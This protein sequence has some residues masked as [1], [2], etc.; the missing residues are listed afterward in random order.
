MDVLALT[1]LTLY[2]AASACFFAV[3]RLRKLHRA[4]VVM[5]AAGLCVSVLE[6]IGRAVSG[7]RLPL[8]S[9]YDFLLGFTSVLV[10]IFLLY[11]RKNPDESAGGVPLFIA[12]A[13]ML[14]LI[15][16]LPKPDVSTPLVPALK[17]P[18]LAVHVLTAIAAYAGFGLA[19]G[20]AAAQL[21]GRYSTAREQS[22]YAFA[23][24]G[25]AMLSLSIILGAIWAEQAWGSYWTWDPKETWAL[26]TWIIYALYLHLY[27][28]PQWRGRNAAWLVVGGFV[29]VLFTFFGVSFLMSGLHSY[30]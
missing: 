3:P 18:W 5:A 30:A 4:A 17:S 29:L 20:L 24:G 15:V 2:A 9:G 8:T 14:A 1:G 23:A 10:F 22:I 7:G 21:A 13:L 27:R 16:L 6:L 12:S 25:F 28:R 26:I 19:A 11:E